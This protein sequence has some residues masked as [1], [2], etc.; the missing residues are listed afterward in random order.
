M[1]QVVPS[2]FNGPE[3]IE[4]DFCPVENFKAN[5]PG[6]EFEDQDFFLLLAQLSPK[7]HHHLIYQQQRKES[8]E[9]FIFFKA[10]LEEGIPCHLIFHWLEF[11]S[12]LNA[13]AAR[14][15]RLSVDS[16]RRGWWIWVT[17]QQSLPQK[18]NL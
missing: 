12:Y 5:V 9:G 14:K 17:S 1:L 8:M 16:E 7:L 2:M 4:F 15:C 18:C 3:A 6:Q 10:L 11:Q 13:R